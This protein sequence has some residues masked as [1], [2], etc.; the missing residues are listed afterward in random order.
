MSES[1][2]PATY[3][4]AGVNLDLG[5][6]ASRLLYGAARHTW[7]QRQGRLGEVIIPHDDF[8]GVRCI[9]VGALPPDTVMGSCRSNGYSLVRHILQRQHGDVW[10]TVPYGQSTLGALALQPAR[11]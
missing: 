5:D 2:N 1:H 11:L 8:S 9:A 10:H 6:A 7:E 4:E 3:A